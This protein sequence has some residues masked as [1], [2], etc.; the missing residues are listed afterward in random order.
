MELTI[1][2]SLLFGPAIKISLPSSALKPEF[3]LELDPKLVEKG[4]DGASVFETGEGRSPSRSTPA[5][6]LRPGVTLVELKSRSR[7]STEDVSS[8]DEF[9]VSELGEQ[10]MPQKSI[11][12]E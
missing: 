1:H 7:M 12:A 9:G 6:C 5:D 3:E 10:K 8:L 11:V 2:L 4:N